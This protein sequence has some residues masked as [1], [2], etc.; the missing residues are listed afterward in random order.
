MM[1]SSFAAIAL[2]L[3]PDGSLFTVL[4]RNQP[5]LKTPSL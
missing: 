3:S 5:G 4:R 2:R 1:S